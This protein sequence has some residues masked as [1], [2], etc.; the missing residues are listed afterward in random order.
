MFSALL[1]DASI[2]FDIQDVNGATPLWLALGLEQDYSI[3]SFAHTLV[4]KNASTDAVHLKTGS[5][6]D[7]TVHIVICHFH[8]IYKATAV[9]LLTERDWRL[10][11][12]ELGLGRPETAPGVWGSNSHTPYFARNEIVDNRQPAPWEYPHRCRPAQG[13]A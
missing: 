7:F 12:L 6:A 8:Q 4:A 1:Q 9:C 13:G 3:S 10:L 2:D 11:P 5:F